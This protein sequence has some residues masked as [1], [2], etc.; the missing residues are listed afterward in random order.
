MS[1]LG[2]Y[3]IFKKVYV[4]A[5]EDQKDKTAHGHIIAGSSWGFRKR[6]DLLYL[7]FTACLAD[8]PPDE[9]EAFKKS[10]THTH[11]EHCYGKGGE[12]KCGF[13]KPLSKTSY[14]CPETGKIILRRITEEDT[15][16]EETNL[17]IWKRFGRINSSTRPVQDV[18]SGCIYCCAYCG[19]EAS[20]E[21]FRLRC[22]EQ[23]LNPHSSAARWVWLNMHHMSSMRAAGDILRIPRLHTPPVEIFYFF[24]NSRLYKKWTARP[25]KHVRILPES[26]FE[27]FVVR[28]KPYVQGA[29][30]GI[31]RRHRWWCDIDS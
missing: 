25:S 3:Q 11:Y 14:V 28:D 20:H 29:L 24:A 19:K 13:P 6:P 26:Y 18:E 9:R 5:E 23:K 16:V 10:Q 21:N 17:L 7:A 22:L 31:F 15:M 27:N 2:V 12:L 1:E 30:K 8:V 4:W